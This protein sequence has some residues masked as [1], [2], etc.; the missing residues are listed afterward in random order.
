MVTRPRTGFVIAA[1][2]AAALAGYA[3]WR[4]AAPP[5]AAPAASGREPRGART[6]LPRIA[7]ERLDRQADASGEPSSSRDIFA[8]GRPQEAGP[9]APPGVAPQAPAPTPPPASSEGTR[10]ATPAAAPPFAVRYVGTVER[11]GLKVAVLMSE[12]KKEILTGREGDTVANRLRIVKIGFES[13][14]VRDVGSERTRRI[15]LRGN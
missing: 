15:P 6:P 1:L 2:V 3:W 7:L 13:V 14:E 8:F 11:E 9:A 12:D 4:E 5:A 10:P